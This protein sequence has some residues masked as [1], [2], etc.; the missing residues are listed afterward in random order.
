MAVMIRTYIITCD[1][2]RARADALNRESGRIYTE[3][4]VAHWRVKR[5]KDIWLSEKS[6]TRWSDSRITATMH[7]HTIDAAQ[8]GFYRACVTTRALRRA[9]FPETRFPHRPKKFRTTVWKVSAIKREGEVLILSCGGRTSKER[10][11]RQ[12]RLPIP[13]HL[14]DM[15]RFVEV[16]LVY[17]QVGRRYTWHLVAEDGTKAKASPGTKVVSVDLGEVHPAVVGDE[18][19][20]EVVTCRQRRAE[21]QGHARRMAK[22]QQAASRKRKGS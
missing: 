4:L 10:E 15:L 3:V 7:A 9:A 11:V 5:K 18:R 12:I 8:Q 17:D 13:E 6:G 20:A 14:R 22:I 1:L 19:A 16:R 21:S 2:P